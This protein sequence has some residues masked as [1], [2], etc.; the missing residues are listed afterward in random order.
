MI[1][2]VVNLFGGPGCGKSTLAAGIVHEL[3]VAGFE[4]IF[5][6]EEYKAAAMTKER[7]TTAEEI[8]IVTRQIENE[9][10]FYGLAE[11]VV[12]DSP[13]EL[14]AFYSDRLRFGPTAY[15]GPWRQLIRK[16]REE[17]T[18]F[19]HNFL[20]TRSVKFDDRGR[21]E[22]ESEVQLVDQ[23]LEA[24][25]ESAWSY[26]VEKIGLC[27]G[28]ASQMIQQARTETLKHFAEAC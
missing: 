28:I 25:L 2:T 12:T 21:Y 10:R 1:T 19:L 11:Y 26:D 22:T 7:P 15:Y 3:K 13:L 18:I 17:N 16:V 27:P 9:L 5:V 4:A 24:Y 6:H 20:V 14:N 23:D 8:Q